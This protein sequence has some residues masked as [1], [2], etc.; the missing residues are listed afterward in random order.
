ME[1][2]ILL[3]GNFVPFLVESS[4]METIEKGL[5]KAIKEGKGDPFHFY[6][7][8][9]V[10]VF[11]NSILG[12]YFRQKIVAPTEKMMEFLDKKMPDAGGG[13]EWKQG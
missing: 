10:T 7:V 8:G 4:E 13:D 6:K 5:I 2:I 11:T 3:N 9:L 1:L 12:W